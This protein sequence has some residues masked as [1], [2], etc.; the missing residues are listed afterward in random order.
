ML[1]FGS[2]LRVMVVT[3]NAAIPRSTSVTALT[4]PV[5]LSPEIEAGTNAMATA[6][7]LAQV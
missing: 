3:D 1:E 4:R 2:A 5:P 6:L 7:L